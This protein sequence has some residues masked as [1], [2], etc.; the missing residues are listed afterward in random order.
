MS[1]PVIDQPQRD[2]ALDPSQSFIVQAPAGSGK[3]GLITQR[4]L[5][6]LAGVQRPEEIVA[7][8]FTRKAA[9]EMRTRILEA[10]H[11]ARGAAPSDPH[12][13]KTWRLACKVLERDAQQGW[14]LLSQPSRLVIQTIDSLCASLTRQLPMMSRFGAQPGV[15]DVAQELYQ[16]AAQH[17]LA[18]LEKGEQWS[19]AIEALLRH[20]DNDLLKAESMLVEM[21]ARRD[22]WLRHLVNINSAP[23][24]RELLESALQNLV[25]DGLARLQGR[26]PSHLSGELLDLLQFACDEPE[27]FLND[28]SLDEL[29]GLPAL[30]SNALRQWQALTGFLLTDADGWRKQANAKLGFPAPSAVKD[31]ELKA[32]YKEMKERYVSL[33]SEL[34]EDEGLL[35]LLVDIRR[36]PPPRFKDSQWQ[37]VEALCEL[38]LIAAGR[39]W[40]V[41]AERGQ[42]DFSEISRSAIQ[43]LGSEDEPTDLGLA[44]DYRIQ[45]LLVD[46]FQDTSFGQYEL[47]Q[48]LTAGWQR[49]DGRTLFVV[50]DPMQSIYRF[51]EAEVGLYLQ[52]WAQGIGDVELVPLKLQVNFRSAAG[53]VDW[54]NDTFQAVLPAQRDVSTGA[55][56]YSHSVPFHAAE[57]GQAVYVHPALEN[58]KPAEAQQVVALI[59]EAYQQRPQGSVAI[60]VRSRPH[61]VEII[62]A[63]KAAGLSYRAIEIEQLTHRPVVQDLY[64]LTRALLH[65]ADRVAWLAVL[66]APW[67]GLSLADLESLAKDEFR[68]PLW[69]VLKDAEIR[70]GLSE[71][72]QQR[73]QQL[74]EVLEPALQLRQQKTLRPWLESVWLALG[75]PAC[76]SNPTD[77]EDAEVY[78][79][80]LEQIEVGGDLENLTVLGDKLAALYALPDVRGDERLQLMTIHRSKGLEFDTVILPGLARPPAKSDHRLLMWMERAGHGAEGELL[81]APVNPVGAARDAVYDYLCRLDKRKGDL[82]LGRL[83]Y[84]AA[85]RARKQLHLLGHVTINENKGELK[86]PVSGSL[87]QL[88]WP[89]V[90]D[91]FEAAYV[92]DTVQSSLAIEKQSE[93]HPPNLQ[94]LSADWQLPIAPALAQQT[95]ANPEEHEV[96]FVWATDVPR[97]VGTVIHGL[98]QRIADQGAAHWDAKRL[99]AMQ[100]QIERLLIQQGVAQQFLSEAVQRVIETLLAMLD[101][102]R[103]RWLLDN[104]H[105]DSQTEYALT[106]VWR[107]EVKRIVI[108]RSFIDANGVRWIIDYKTAVHE[109]GELDAFLDVEKEQYQS[110]LENYAAVMAKNEPRPIMLGLYFPLYHGWRSWAYTDN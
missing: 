58:D 30:D 44:L 37:L 98:L 104:R 108:D 92:A 78:F 65:P 86:T 85:T 48:R 34:Q 13:E 71:E 31:K 82:E 41:F 18:D 64:A 103:G 95:Y 16:Q 101:D 66:R 90:R 24:R 14:A 84:V 40:M 56:E 91:V 69:Q 1:S 39:L 21:L 20:L 10:L 94:R 73:L 53:V 87:L 32:R 81:L 107:D 102:P 15:S 88:L 93:V 61:L 67:C 105:K 89:Q 4:F 11:F 79:R 46:E 7:I 55:V 42:V 80:L 51:R 35:D 62:P 59:R 26:I 47:L 96:E 60:L 106:S 33:I 76:V 17:T 70:S 8:T 68:Q 74:V 100:F 5:V 49:G 83:L 63:L 43:A 3:T 72:G 19:N 36:L 28:V 75:G 2:A 77:L 9:G 50:G 25:D 57:A 97:H 99:H 23:Q 54:V 38:L 12:A 52:A 29:S 22:Q 6:L 45:H 110:Q 27:P 109:S